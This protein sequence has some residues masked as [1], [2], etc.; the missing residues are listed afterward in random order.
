MLYS[1]HEEGR[2]WDNRIGGRLRIDSIII[3]LQ[4]RERGLVRYA[5]L[6]NSMSDRFRTGMY[7]GTQPGE[8]KET[9]VDGLELR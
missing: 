3:H 7:T 2:K 6:G 8:L 5:E 9:L 4:R 1:T